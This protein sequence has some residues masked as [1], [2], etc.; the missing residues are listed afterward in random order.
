MHDVQTK[1]RLKAFQQLDPSN[2]DFKPMIMTLM[3]DLG[4]HMHAEEMEDL[5]ILE[6][7]LSPRESRSL[8]KSFTRTK[9]FVPSRA[10]PHL[11][12][13]PPFE[14][15]VG[16]VAAPFDQMMDLFRKWPHKDLVGPG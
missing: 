14:T 7:T 4:R 2:K 12:S 6:E 15:A 1:N 5:A 13:K 3:D 8:A 16:L 10:H 11:P 9:I